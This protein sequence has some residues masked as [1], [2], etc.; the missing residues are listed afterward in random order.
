[1]TDDVVLRELYGF[2]ETVSHWARSTKF[3]RREYEL[4]LMEDELAESHLR[5]KSSDC[6]VSSR[7]LTVMHA[8]LKLFLSC[9]ATNRV[10][11]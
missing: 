8:Y 11:M 5:K 4:L 3:K 7:L 9:H 10:H 6:E 2:F 1:M